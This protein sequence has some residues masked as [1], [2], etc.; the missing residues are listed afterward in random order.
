M[1]ADR[2]AAQ[3][4]GFDLGTSTSQSLAESKYLAYLA[5]TR[6]GEFLY[7]SHPATDRKGRA[8]VKSGFVTELENL[9]ES[10]EEES[11]TDEQLDFENIYCESEF[12]DLLCR[13]ITEGALGKNLLDE[14]CSDKQLGDAGE[15]IR[16][17]I[18]YSNKPVLEKAIAKEFFGDRVESSVTRLGTFAGCPYKH[19]A[20]YLLGLKEREQFKLRPLEM[21]DFYHRVLDGWLKKVT[22]LNIDFDSV[23]DAELVKILN[24]QI[25]EI[26]QGDSFISNFADRSRHNS[27]I[28]NSAGEILSDFVISAAQMIRAGRFRPT[29]SEIWFGGTDELGIA[30]SKGRTLILRGKIDR[31]D[32]FDAGDEKIAVVFDYKRSEKAFNWSKLY[33][34][35]DLQLPVYMLAVENMKKADRIAGAFYQPIEVGIE[36][37]A[38][39]KLDQQCGGFKH[40]GKG[41][42]SGEFA[43]QLD[44]QAKSGWSQFYSFYISSK[45]GQYGD[46]R[47]SAALKPADFEKVLGFA[48][49]KIAELAKGIIAGSIEVYPY[50]LGTERGCQWCEYG[51]VC[52]FDWLANDYNELKSVDKKKLLAQGGSADG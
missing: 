42:F 27:F 43:E 10:L 16:C 15:L 30:I 8:T 26:V 21:G 9:F 31:L 48:K 46:Y 47:R 14:I 45:D 4:S 2:G 35:L 49:D 24:E 41:I 19:F 34:G 44:S 38:V 11:T 36:K 12:T 51:A 6:A 37:V 29:E 18:D 3:R 13:R 32:I 23:S 50:K 17:A 28:I 33:H 1:D 7:V 20:R 22:K 25:L 40:K 5:F 52:R 39:N